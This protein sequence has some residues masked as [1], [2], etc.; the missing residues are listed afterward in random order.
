MKRAHKGDLSKGFCEGFSTNL[1][2]SK[3]V[4]NDLLFSLDVLT[5][6]SLFH[7]VVLSCS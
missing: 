4:Q 3:I 7:T 5:V 1:G 2:N 6:F